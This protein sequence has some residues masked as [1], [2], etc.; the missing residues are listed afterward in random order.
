VKRSEN[1][2]TK[3]QQKKL[4]AIRAVDKNESKTETVQHMESLSPLC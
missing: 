2:Q 1:K 3:Q 4:K